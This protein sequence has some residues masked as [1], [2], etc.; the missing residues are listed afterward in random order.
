MK[1]C[2]NC[3][4]AHP[5]EARFC[6]GCG[7]AFTETSS[8][9]QTDQQ[10]TQRQ[11]E[12]KSKTLYEKLN[13]YMGNDKPASLHWNVLYTDVFK[14]HTTSE[15]ENIFIR[16]TES[17]IPT[18]ANLLNDWPRPW[19]YSR[20]LFAMLVTFFLLY[21]CVDEFNNENA[22]PGLIIV[23]SFAVPLSVMIMF[24]ELNAYRNISMYQVLKMFF[25]G[26]AASL[27]VTLTL[28]R[29]VEL[30][31]NMG[32]GEAILVGIIEEVGKAVIVY[33]FLKSLHK[34]RHSILVG[35]LVGGCVGAGFAAFESSGY[36]LSYF[37]LDV[38]FLRGIL[39][40]GGHVAWAAIT[41]AGM[42]MA[43]SGRKE[44]KEFSAEVLGDS[45]FLRLFIIPIILHAL[46]DSPLS[47]IVGSIY[48]WF[49]GLILFVWIVVMIIVQMG[50]NQLTKDH[51]MV[52]ASGSPNTSQI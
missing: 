47:G 48:I 41:G 13:E 4:K 44:C 49:G 32:F 24:F 21:I 17:T 27:V 33:Y 19:L 2:R 3:G 14:K 37:T 12:H 11:N 46:W 6:A 16:G 35:L 36:A 50:L 22:I 7:Q 5:D 31:N 42:E 43:F 15:A 25:I 34:T 38:I 18:R 8:S 29:F 30:G 20:I 45:R 23:G 28:F 26:G 51:A 39:A 40:P 9:S 1:Y 10:S 52:V